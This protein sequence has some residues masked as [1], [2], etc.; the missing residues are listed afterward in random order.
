[1]PWL[2]QGF[3]HRLGGMRPS[4]N[5]EIGSCSAAEMKQVVA[6]SQQR[7]PGHLP[8]AAQIAKLVSWRTNCRTT[9]AG[10]CFP[11]ET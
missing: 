9:A 1:M 7:T 3:Y 4:R 10:Q 6:F 11:M 5:R 8:L 2:F